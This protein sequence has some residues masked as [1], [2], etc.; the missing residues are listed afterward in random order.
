MDF[1]RHPRQGTMACLIRLYITDFS[2]PDIIDAKGSRHS[3]DENMFY[4]TGYVALMLRAVCSEN[5]IS[6]FICSC[7]GLP[8][9]QPTVAVT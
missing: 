3:P 4:T 9:A 5:I 7:K 1:P 2:I 8:L 6:V